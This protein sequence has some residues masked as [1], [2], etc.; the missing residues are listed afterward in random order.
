M[1]PLPR[2]IYAMANDGL[3]FRFLGDVHPKYKTP[4][5]GT[6][7]AGVITGM[8]SKFYSNLISFFFSLIKFYFV[9]GIMAAMFKL[10][11]LVNML[12]IGTLVAYTIVAACVLLL[13]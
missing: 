8:Y 2:V 9:L 4:L 7:L 5:V 1:Y 12:S 13:R 10:Q 3:I 11:Q 6:L